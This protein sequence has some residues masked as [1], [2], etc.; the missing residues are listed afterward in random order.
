[1]N[2]Q[3]GAY[4]GNHGGVYLPARLTPGKSS[5]VIAELIPGE[6]FGV[7]AEVAP[8]HRNGDG[9]RRNQLAGAG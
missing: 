4:V 7:V 6:H 5:G 3:V 9:T 8:S 2:V 1:M